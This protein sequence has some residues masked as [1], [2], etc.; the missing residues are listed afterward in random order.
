MLAAGSSSLP[1]TP[2]TPGLPD[3]A[4]SRQCALTPL[5]PS[6]PPYSLAAYGYPYHAA[7]AAH[8][9]VPPAFQGLEQQ[10]GDRAG[11]VGLSAAGSGPASLSG[12]L[13][14]FGSQA[15]SAGGPQGAPSLS[16]E[17][18]AAAATMPGI[19]P[20]GHRMQD[21]KGN[22]TAAPTAQQAGQAHSAGP[23]AV[24]GV[25]TRMS[26]RA[27]A[28]G[29]ASS[30]HEQGGVGE[31]AATQEVGEEAPCEDSTKGGS[32]SQSVFLQGGGHVGKQHEDDEAGILEAAGIL[33]VRFHR[34]GG[35][36]LPE[37]RLVCSMLG[38]MVYA[39]VGA[40]RVSMF[41]RYESRGSCVMVCY[42]DHLYVSLLL[43]AWTLLAPS[44]GKTE[45][46]LQ[47][48]GNTVTKLLYFP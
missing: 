3:A 6:I 48:R 9:A 16:A 41:W 45:Y 2:H 35:R 33:Q 27:G 14:P 31:A 4:S 10:Q 18:A 26:L 42:F 17:A 32:S 39:C 22:H 20:V 15:P 40:Y 43:Q 36:A 23:A 37:A 12:F 8:L 1:H 25:P 13:S 30:S 21:A 19:E 44:T 28:E 46:E 24:H 5:G 34:G 38:V 11:A 29:R 7:A 47:T